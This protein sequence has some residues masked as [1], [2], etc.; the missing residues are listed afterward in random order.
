MAAARILPAGLVLGALV[1]DAGGRHGLA[2]YLLLAGVP[3]AAWAALVLFGRLVDL[4]AR[5]RGEAYVRFETSLASLA[6]VLV[7]V[8]AAA[9]SQGAVGTD[10]PALTASAVGA[11]LLLY[12]L[13]AL[14]AIVAPRPRL[15]RRTRV[16]APAADAA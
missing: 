1:A 3:A 12:L 2:S 5:T 7:L 15:P 11:A 14:T 9:R 16:A 10:V 8:A 4:P 6:L 13:Q